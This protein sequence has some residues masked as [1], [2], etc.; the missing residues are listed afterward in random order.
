MRELTHELRQGDPAK[1]IVDVG[2]II[3]PKQIEIA[4]KH[5]AGRRRQGRRGR[6]GRQ[7][8][9]GAGAVLRAHGARRLQPHDDGDDR[10]DLRPIVPFMKV[11]SEEEA[12]RLANESHL[13]LNAYVF[14]AIASTRHRL[15]ERMQAGSVLVNDVLSNGGSPRRPSAA[16]SRAASAASMGDDSLR[17][18]CDVRHISVDPRARR[19]TSPLW[20]PYTEKR[21][22][23][24]RKAMKV[25]F[26]GGSLVKKIGQLF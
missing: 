13:G 11:A 26:G 25:L 24:V 14:S 19:R 4:E 21:L 16:S 8:R 3:F 7:A 9:A 15:A 10:G 1:E 22:S 20:F 17:E 23:M 12:V 6:S 2:A 18:M 5:I